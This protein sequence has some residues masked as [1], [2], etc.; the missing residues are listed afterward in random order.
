[1]TWLRER[2]ISSAVA[3]G[4]TEQWGL[5]R[6]CQNHQESRVG[7]VRLGTGGGTGSRMAQG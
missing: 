7:R 6:N 2:R 5:F 3:E 4:G 1:M